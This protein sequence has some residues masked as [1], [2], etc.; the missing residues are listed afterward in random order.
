LVSNESI[1]L[2]SS[3]DHLERVSVL[4]QRRTA[5][6]RFVDRALSFAS[7]W[8]GRPGSREHDLAGE[9]RSVIAPYADTEGLVRE[10]LERHALIARRS[11]DLTGSAKK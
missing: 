1:F 11:C 6:D 10:V 2:E 9:I 8:H 5:I 3:F 7:T 4:E